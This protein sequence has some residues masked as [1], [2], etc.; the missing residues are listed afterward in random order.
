MLTDST[1]ENFSAINL[2]EAEI[3]QLK[4]DIPAAVTFC[5]LV[6]IERYVSSLNY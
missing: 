3:Q 2:K 4:T 6:D 1:P 5:V